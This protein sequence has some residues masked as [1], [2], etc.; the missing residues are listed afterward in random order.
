MISEPYLFFSLVGWRFIVLRM[1]RVAL[2]FAVV[3]FLLHHVGSHPIEGYLGHLCLYVLGSFAAAMVPRRVA[4]DG[5]TFSM[6]L[7]GSWIKNATSAPAMPMLLKQE[8]SGD[9][10]RIVCMFPLSPDAKRHVPLV[11]LI[12]RSQDIATLDQWAATSPG[13]KTEPTN[14]SHAAGVPLSLF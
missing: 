12:V 8:L 1:A 13:S 3:E 14:H 7:Y 9:L 5:H 2:I 4:F 6:R 11:D 10:Y